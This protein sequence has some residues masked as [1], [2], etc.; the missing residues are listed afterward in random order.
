MELPMQRTQRWHFLN[1]IE[2]FG[3]DFELVVLKFDYGSI[4]DAPTTFVIG[5][6]PRRAASPGTN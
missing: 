3:T 6:P 4:T 1:L 2:I 5:L